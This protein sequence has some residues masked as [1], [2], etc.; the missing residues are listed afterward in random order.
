MKLILVYSILAL[1]LLGCSSGPK[2]QSTAGPQ[3]IKRQIASSDFD[4]ISAN[5]RLEQVVKHL[6]ASLEQMPN[7]GNPRF[8]IFEHFV[9]QA[10]ETISNIR[11][12]SNENLNQN[13]F[14]PNDQ[15]IA[16][17]YLELVSAY[18]AMNSLGIYLNHSMIV[19][20]D[21]PEVINSLSALDKVMGIYQD[22]LNKNFSI[23]VRIEERENAL[24]KAQ[25]SLMQYLSYRVYAYHETFITSNFK[26]RRIKRLVKTINNI[27]FSTY[28]EFKDQMAT[29]AKSKNFKR[30]NKYLSNLDLP[31]SSRISGHKQAF[32]EVMSVQ[33]GME[34]ITHLTTLI[35]N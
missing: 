19:D 12:I 24:A 27:K 4:G 26:K 22:E 5:E 15:D 33:M 35:A 2:W 29:I 28:G 34:L 30:V 9:F 11:K 23:I 32:E 18:K 6:D 14:I 10:K 3:M 17:K 7:L 31:D 16:R 13:V 25:I 1:T 8:F 20:K 21:E